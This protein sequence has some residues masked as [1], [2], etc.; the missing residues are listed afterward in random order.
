MAIGKLP[1][2]EGLTYDG[3]CRVNALAIDAGTPAMIYA[4]TQGGVFTSSNGEERII[5]RNP[6]IT[7]VFWG[8][9]EVCL[10][11]GFGCIVNPGPQRPPD[12]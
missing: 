8:D 4:G 1:V 12:L 7:T 5:F 9:Y 3:S 6:D 11:L 10:P 2:N